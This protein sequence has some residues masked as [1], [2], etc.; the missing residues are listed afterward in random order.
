[1]EDFTDVFDVAQLA[2]VEILSPTPQETEDFFTTFLGMQVTDRDGQSSYLRAYEETYHH[3]LKI[4]ESPDSGVDHVA[5]R[6]RS[7]MALDRRVNALLDA[8]VTG[9]W[10]EDRGHGQAFR[11]AL[12]SGQDFELFWDVE[13]WDVPEEDR[14]PLLNRASRRPTQGVPVRRIDH[15]TITAPDVRATRTF[16]H[17]T[18]GFQTREYVSTDDDSEDLAAWTSISVLVHELAIVRDPLQAPNRLH[19]VCYWYGIPQHCA[20]I[21]EVL[22]EHGITVECGPGKHGIAQGIFLYAI[23][24]GGNRIEVYGDTGYLIQDPAWKPLRWTESQLD[25]IKTVY[26]YIA[27]EPF[28]G[29]ATPPNGTPR[30]ITT[31]AL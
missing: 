11:F 13:Y 23:E 2:H 26:G 31:A 24:P 29:Y 6:A 19:H 14:T 18:L 17:D 3:S 8:G 20:D 15:V 16:L 12:P 5:F 1:M 7:P 21:A 22:R 28:F 10:V 4:T 27:S 30:P 9:E 25:W